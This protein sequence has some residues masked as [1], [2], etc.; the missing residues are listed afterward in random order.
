MSNG[1]TVGVKNLQKQSLTKQLRL[2]EKVSNEN[3]Q[4][5]LL[6]INK[7]A[8]LSEPLKQSGFE[9]SRYAIPPAI[10]EKHKSSNSRKNNSYI[11]RMITLT[12]KEEALKNSS[13]S[14]LKVFIENMEG[15]YP[16]A[17]IMDTQGQISSL[18]PFDENNSDV[19]SLIN[20]YTDTLKNEINNNA[21]YDVGVLSVDVTIS[22][23]T[24]NGTIK[25]NGIEMTFFE[26]GKKNKI[27]H[28]KYKITD[29]DEI[30]FID[31]E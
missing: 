12:Q 2:Q 8:T 5:T 23:K 15:F 16:F 19:Q 6:R 13:L 29:D 28:V 24:K 20:L 22:K 21:L 30:C 17:M 9:F 11:Q 25:E 31:D 10:P 4:K 27:I 14:Y 18:M 3:G 1:R 7:D 26:K